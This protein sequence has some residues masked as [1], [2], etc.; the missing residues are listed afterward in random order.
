ML[1]A[2]I[3][4]AGTI[5]TFSPSLMV[6][7]AQAQPYD[8]GMDRD[9]ESDR[10]QVVSVSSFE[11]N[12]NNINVNGI[13][14]NVTSFPFLSELAAEL[15]EASE[16]NYGASS[17]GSDGSYGGH[18]DKDKD[19]FRVICINNNIPSEPPVEECTEAE[20]NAIEVCFEENMS[21]RDFGLLT[22]AL[23]NGITIETEE[24][25]SVTLNSFA[26]ICKALKG[27]TTWEQLF[28]AVLIIT[29][30]FSD[31]TAPVAI[32][33]DLIDCIAEAL[34]IPLPS[35]PPGG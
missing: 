14:L 31:P 6:R 22:N 3:L 29:D 23:E 24:G 2:V 26:D 28:T 9:R 32:S 18:S 12:N 7:T 16:G 17:Y 35:P 33:N 4:V 8:G 34:G 13:E 19:D 1:L 25:N 5:A 21:P 11:C 20:A 27:I 10:K 30:E 15:A